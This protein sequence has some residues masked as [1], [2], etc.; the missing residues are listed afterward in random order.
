MRKGI[1]FLFLLIVL[2]QTVN[3]LTL[4]PETYLSYTGSN[5]ILDTRSMGKVIINA[6]IHLDA[7]EQ[8]NL[9]IYY[10]TETLQG[11]ISYTRPNWWTSVITLKLGDKTVNL[12][13]YDILGLE[14]CILLTYSFDEQNKTTAISLIYD[15]GSIFKKGI[16]QEI[17]SL[18]YTPIYRLDINA[19][20]EVKV[21]VGVASYQAYKEGWEVTK[22]GGYP[23]IPYVTDLTNIITATYTL[24]TGAFWYFKLIFVDNWLLTFAL[25]ESLLLAYSACTSRDIFQFYRRWIDAH[26]KLVEIMV[27]F[28]RVL[29][30]IFSKVIQAIKPF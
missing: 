28:V 19:N 18:E 30:D 8:A 26:I 24:I 16:E 12:T 23:E 11:Y 27:G 17:P 22:Q 9:T 13:D 15:D 6:K 20:G 7:G 10:G 25:F 5:L 4:E 3:A 21:V 1:L 2:I 29:V 14:K